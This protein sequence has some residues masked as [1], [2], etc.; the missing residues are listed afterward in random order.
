M[1]T[2]SFIP[3]KDASLESTI[4][5]MQAKLA[6]RGFHLD[7]S[8]LLNPVEAIWSV[9]MKDHECPMLFSNGKGATELAARASALGEFFERLGTHYFWT[10]FYLGATRANRPFVHY[11][12]E[13]WFAPT[14]DGR[15]PVEMMNPALHSFYNPNGE[16]DS[17]VLVDLNS[18]NI[19]RG[20]CTLPY[21]RL[22][23]GEQT[24]IPVNI[25]GN[26]YVS[27]GMAAGNTMMEARSQALS[28]IFERHIKYR[29]I[30]EGLCLPEVPDE[31]IARYP[32]IAAGIKGLR[33]AG[34]GILVRDASLGGR[35]PVM[36]VTLLHPGDQGL[37][38]SFG[39][40]PRFEI[41]LERAL[42]ELLQGRALASLEG[43]P[44]PGFDMDEITAVANLEIHFVDS[45]GVVSWDFL[46]D[47]PDFPFADWNFSN[48]TE[49]DY[50][51]LCAA[52]AAEDKDIYVSDF[53]EQG[54][55]SCRILVPGMSEIYPVEDLEWEN[56]SVGNDIRPA[57][58]RLDSL[59]EEECADLL[60]YLQT[61]NLN[62]ERPL[63]EI[64][65]LAI[66]AGTTW[67]EL[68]IGE[69]KTLLALA[70]GDDEAIREGCDW[71]HQYKQM[72][73]AR[74]LVYRCIDSLVQLGQDEDYQRALVLLYGADT[75]R[76]ATALL[77]RSE[78]FFGLATLGPDMEGS[79]M[80]QTLLAAYDKLFATAA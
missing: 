71:I 32:G 3:G 4:R 53:S 31:V 25:I 6:G 46:G 18:G 30:S 44:E 42:T 76:Q 60:A 23:D 74:R 73:P 22:R 37:F 28:E 75:V 27:N 20:I 26:L 68:R 64:L 63:W 39:A 62:D 70:I 12:Q 52:V 15:W 11:P 13:R 49:E 72:N 56:N 36:C 19:A 59:N 16:I 14:E 58:V 80:H 47:T 69:L 34:F 10:H 5:T 79:A 8:S 51:W 50:N 38:A 54:A 7:E 41:A 45:S 77:D 21:T 2:E 40:H 33:D 17:Q 1:H 48:T 24:W 43:F 55:Y 9:H 29:I 67:K 66:P 61:S 35:Y 65:G 78:Y 57:L